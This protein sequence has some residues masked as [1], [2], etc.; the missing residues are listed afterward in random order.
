MHVTELNHEE[1]YEL[2]CKLHWQTCSDDY[3]GEYI[4]SEQQA[5]LDRTEYAD[6]IPD[7]LVFEVFDGYD[8]VEDDFWCNEKYEGD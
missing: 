6:D 1:L 4:T 2:K 5:I 7:K 3:S 8:F